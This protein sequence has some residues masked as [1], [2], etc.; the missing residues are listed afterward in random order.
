MT[1][2]PTHK[3]AAPMWTKILPPCGHKMATT[4][5]PGGKGSWRQSTLQG[6]AVRGV[7][8]GRGEKLGANRLAGE[9]LDINQAGMGMVRGDQVGRQKQLGAIRKGGRRTVGS[10][11]SWIVRGI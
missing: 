3:M 1:I 4:R 10:Q 6:R 8:A 11:Q 2:T 5:W 9:Q 7:Q